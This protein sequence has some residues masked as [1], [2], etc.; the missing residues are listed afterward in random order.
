VNQRESFKSF[1]A[2]C[3]ESAEKIEE[4]LSPQIDTDQNRRF[5]AKGA[6]KDIVLI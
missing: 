3:A 2:E 6:K 1:T 5:T 4:P